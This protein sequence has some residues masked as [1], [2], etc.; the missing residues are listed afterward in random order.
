MIRGKTRSNR[1]A[2][3]L[4]LGPALLLL[5]LS[6]LISAAPA[7]AVEPSVKITSLIPDYVTPGK[8]VA[9]YVAAQNTG[10]QPLSGSLTFKYVFPEGVVPAEPTPPFDANPPPACSTTAQVVECTVDVN[11]IQPGSQIRY[12]TLTQVE[13][14]ATGVLSG[15][16]EVSG[17]GLP[18][19]V[20]EPLVLDT[21]PIGPFAIKSLEVEIAD[22]S[23]FPASQAGVAPSELSTNVSLYSEART[24]LGLPQG[25]VTAPSESFSDVIAHVPPGFVGDPTATPLRCTAAQ[26]ATPVKFD[27]NAPIPDTS[28]P[29]CPPESQIGV[30]QLNGGDIVT[31]WNLDPP[32][33]S[34]AAFGFYY[35]TLPIT[36]LAKVRP[37][38][39]GID[40]VTERASSS[41][42]ISRFSVTLWGVPGDSS[43]DRLRWVCID[44]GAGYDPRKGDCSLRTARV[45]FLRT[46]TSCPGTDLPWGIEINTY[47]HPETFVRAET[48]T[49]ATEGCEKLPFDPSISLTPDSRGA[50][51][52]AGLDVNL[53]LPQDNGPDGLAEADLKAA[54]V[55]LPQGLTVNPASADGLVAC[56]DAQIRLG[57][58]GPSQCPDAAKL[59]SVAVTTPLLDH[60][61]GGSVFLRSQASGDPESGDLYRLAIELRSDDDGLAIKLPGSLRA[62]RDTGRL[63]ATFADLPQLPFES[64]HLRFKTGPR[65]PLSTP[66]TCGTYNTHATLSSW[67]GKTVQVDSTFTVD[68]NCAA[69]PF[70]P[71]F[72]A[73]VGNSTAGEFSPFSLRVTR[74]RGQPNLSRIEVTL[75]EGELARLAGV[76]VCSGVQAAA[77]ACPPES[78]IG[79]VVAA[80]GEG[81]SPLYLPQAGKGP[82]AV[83]LAAPYKGAPY[84]V[85]TEVPAQAG[86]FDLGKVLVRSALRVDPETTAVSVISDPLPQ[87]VAGVPVAYRDLRI[88]IDRPKFSLN[89]TDCEPSAVT[90]TIGSTGGD[91][92]DVSQR[93][94]AADCAALGFR[95]KLVLTLKG[96][97]KRTGH[98]ALKAVLTYPKKG[99]FANIARASVALPGSEFLAQ[100]HIRT[101]CTRVQFAAGAGNGAGCPKGS[102]YGRGMA[103]SPLL[104][105]PLSG[106]VYLRSSNNPLPDL[107]AAL[108]GQID[109][110]LVGRID[111]ENGGIRSTFARV[112]DAPISRFVLRM[113][114]GRR[115]LLENST[116]ICR[117]VHRATVRFDAQNGRISDFNPAVKVECGG[118]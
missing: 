65:A 49:A 97:T 112:P 20:I 15:R 73:G 12:K 19:T 2:G 79:S 52:P 23:T 64:M 35:L 36:L 92:V 16:I 100:S 108:H 61:I 39:H 44:R 96:K 8:G 37:S 59:G 45:P 42:P 4:R 87:I 75:P 51:S 101:I 102:I 84:S 38:D 30:V 3:S 113:P 86:P 107:V 115:S 76:G 24:N 67:S 105:R 14:G 29:S 33:G 53:T 10:P 26:L 22:A 21:S 5:A 55:N 66:S 13:A 41:A 88:Q 43:H 93:F 103:V 90:G 110:N 25:I 83:Y 70:A 116:N 85:L 17:D 6:A 7:A 94:Q 50:H 81:L 106:P 77:G 57:L 95:P 34:P 47:Q 58:E 28:T 40:I 117:G 78:R 31:L 54:T 27:P 69:R 118:K 71:G 48:T 18:V 91:S 46:P 99:A 56:D 60:P 9:I 62:N 111:S 98:P 11:G 74:G 104:D 72:Q 63:T 1:F 109:V 32:A 114:G 80:I 89:P 82:T 68:E